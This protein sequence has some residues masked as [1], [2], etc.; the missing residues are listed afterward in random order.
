MANVE[1]VMAVI[2]AT[3]PN[4]RNAHDKVGF[5][6]HAMFL[7]SGYYL[8]ATGSQACPNTILLFP[9]SHE[10]G[11]DGWNQ[12]E[13]SY[14]FVYSKIEKDGFMYAIL[15]KCV[16]MGDFLINVHDYNGGGDERTT[17]FANQ[18]WNFD[19]LVKKL[20]MEM[21]SKLED[22]PHQPIDSTSFDPERNCAVPPWHPDLADNSPWLRRLKEAHALW[23]YPESSRTSTPHPETDDHPCSMA[24]DHALWGCPESSRPSTPHPDVGILRNSDGPDCIQFKRKGR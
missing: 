12:S 2:R 6:L 9:P 15:V 14:R 10:V 17:N 21:L 4:F 3:R 7:N 20:H 5:A 22:T 8:T 1:G 19:Q 16:V 18:Y 23:G 13:D 11:I 24:L